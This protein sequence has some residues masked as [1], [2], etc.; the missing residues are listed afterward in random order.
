MDR[1]ERGN[2]DVAKAVRL[3]VI[4]NAGQFVLAVE[5]HGRLRYEVRHRRYEYLIAGEASAVVSH[6][7]GDRAADPVTLGQSS[8]QVLVS[9]NKSHGPGADEI[10]SLRERHH[11]VHGR[12]SFLH[13]KISLRSS[14]NSAWFLA[15]KS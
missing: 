13:P 6:E 12:F 10:G 3:V 8:Q 1:G 11:L 14:C 9:S 7:I 15:K 5:L 2:H 4:R